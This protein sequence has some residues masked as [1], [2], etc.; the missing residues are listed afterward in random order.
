MS[1]NPLEGCKPEINYPCLWQ[2]K[3]IG[4]DS[5]AIMDV[6]EAM[7]VNREYLLSVSNRSS[8]GRYVSM[9]L[10][11]VVSTEEERLEFYNQL[12]NDPSIKTVI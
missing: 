9:N 8:S 7:I 11:L 12:I 3:I 1:N 2:Y 10:E 4:S 5:N 6:V